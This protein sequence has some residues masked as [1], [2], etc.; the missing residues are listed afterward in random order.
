MKV[1]IIIPN[2]N[3]VEKLKTHLPYVL[4]AVKSNNIEEI[5]VADDAST[6]SS[7]EV[8]NKYFKEVK[9]IKHNKNLGFSSNVNAGV[10]EAKTDLIYL[11][12]SD[13]HPDI[14]FLKPLVVHLNNPKVFSV[15]SNVGA[16]WAVGKFENGFFWH[17]KGVL[18]EGEKLKAHQTLWVSG[19]SGL[20]RKDIWDEFSGLDPLFNPFYE[21]DMD[22]GYRTTK[23]GYINIWEPESLV[24][25]YKEK[26]VIATHFSQNNVATVAQRNQLIFIWKNITDPEF[27]SEHELKLAQMLVS[28]P[29]YWKIFLSAAKFIPEIR[30]KRKL[31]KKMF[32][33]TDKE[34]ISM[35]QVES[36]KLTS[37]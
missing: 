30:R 22:L 33:L 20:F 37:I 10:G 16:L 6:D 24:E 21:E 3:G 26:G 1:T 29:K 32:K 19:G 23:S 31:L 2:W 17:G 14:N 13:A 9:V 5:I 8:L 11:L 35:F 12:N 4:K 25:H 18:K 27:I 15:G 36:S 34:V 28:H 7:L